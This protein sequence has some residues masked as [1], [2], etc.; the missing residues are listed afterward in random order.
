MA[1]QT[2]GAAAEDIVALGDDV[3]AID[4]R[5]AGYPGITSS[6]LIRSE[7]PC[8]VEVGT[9]GS[10]PVLRDALHSLGVEAQDLA[11]VVVTHIHLDHAGGTGEIARMFPNAE[12]IVHERGARHLADPTRLMNS[13]RM[14]WGDRLEVLFGEMAPTEATRIR[15][16]DTGATID[17]GAGRTLT[18]YYSPGHAKH[19]IGLVDSATGDLYVGDAAGMYNPYTGDVRPATPP[20]DFNLAAALDSLR[21]FSDIK[22]QRL[23]FSHFGAVSDVEPVLERSVEELRLWVETVRESHSTAGDLDHAVALVRERVR[24]RYRPLPDEVPQGTQEVLEI[25]C[26]EEGNVSGIMH[27]LDRLAAEQAAAAQDSPRQ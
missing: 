19:H 3:F 13:A 15:A 4:T 26:G 6:Y 22:P 14:V 17:L 25:L 27:W 10:A 23:M 24:E 1:E 21:L 12:I 18:A 8:V 5:M 9:A 11:T 7:R 20:P 16:V 2:A